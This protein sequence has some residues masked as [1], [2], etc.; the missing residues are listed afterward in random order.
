MEHTPQQRARPESIAARNFSDDLD[1][2]FGLNS[3]TTLG[4]LS[5][6]VQEKSRT[7]STREEELAAIEARLRETEERLARAAHSPDH[8]LT[9]HQAASGAQPSYASRDAVSRQTSGYQSYPEQQYQARPPN[10]R[11][12]SF[13]PHIP[14]AM[15]KTPTPHYGQ[16]QDYV[17]VDRTR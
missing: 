3:G 13:Q 16:G 17:T 14:G 4:N 10:N 15:P 7:V 5:F 9:S 11:E 8:E 1:S 12:E 6:T 2:L